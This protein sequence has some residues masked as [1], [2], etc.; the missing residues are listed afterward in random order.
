MREGATALVLVR[1]RVGGHGTSHWDGSKLLPHESQHP[2]STCGLCWLLAVENGI[3]RL[4]FLPWV[5]SLLAAS[6]QEL[7]TNRGSGC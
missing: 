4:V 7:Q 3:Q 6:N 5:C 2:R 1:S